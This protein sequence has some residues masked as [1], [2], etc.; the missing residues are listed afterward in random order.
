MN[1]G[2]T[3]RK[4]FN[5]STE[6]DL[7]RKALEA[8]KLADKACKEA[9]VRLTYA[10]V[11]PLQDPSQ[12]L[13]VA[14]TRVEAKIAHIER[15]ETAINH[16]D[17]VRLDPHSQRYRGEGYPKLH[18]ITARTVVLFFPFDESY[19]RYKLSD[20]TSS[21]ADPLAGCIERYDLIRL[22]RLASQNKP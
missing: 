5:S 21:K 9:G 4:Q 12:L 7:A 10:D 17:L 16:F 19:H 15:S 3:R 6:L 13:Q 20:G 8:L 2:S 14:S 18:E 22:Q 1:T 11:K